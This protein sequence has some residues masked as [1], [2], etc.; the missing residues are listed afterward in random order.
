M[1]ARKTKM[2]NKRWPL[3]AAPEVQ[4]IKKMP[5]WKLG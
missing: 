5:I 3:A 4:L 1:Q 2:V